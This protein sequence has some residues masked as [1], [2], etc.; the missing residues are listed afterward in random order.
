M[1]ISLIRDYGYGKWVDI[2]RTGKLRAQFRL[3][4]TPSQVQHRALELAHVS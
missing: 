2:A 4:R 1:L 3:C